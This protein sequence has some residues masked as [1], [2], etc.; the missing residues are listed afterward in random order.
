MRHRI[1]ALLFSVCLAAASASAATIT[2]NQTNEDEPNDYPYQADTLNDNSG[3][4][5]CVLA[6]AND[7]DYYVFT[8]SVP[9][10]LLTVEAVGYPTDTYL[11]ILDSSETVIAF[12]DDSGSNLN[13]KITN[14]TLAAAGTYYIEV[15]EAFFQGGSGYYYHLTGQIVE[16]DI[17]DTTPPTYSGSPGISTAVRTDPTRVDVTWN[18]ATD[19]ISSASNIRY[20]VYYSA[21]PGNVF[22]GFPAATVVGTTTTTINGLDP[23]LVYYFGVRAEDEA[24]NEETNSITV[25]VEI[26]LAANPAVWQLYE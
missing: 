6:Q 1:T 24:G 11:L 18:A 22:A 23:S 10:C 26:L 15:T 12:D 17:V 25:T 2:I 16:P 3:I 19:D 4:L 8:T 7:Y 13:A 9:N 14:L 20:N 21:V 5:P